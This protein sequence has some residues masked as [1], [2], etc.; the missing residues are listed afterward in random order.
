MIYRNIEFTPYRNFTKKEKT[1]E[2]CPEV[3][4]KLRHIASFPITDMTHAEF[5]EKAKEQKEIADAYSVTLQ[6][7]GKMYVVPCGKCFM[8]ID[9]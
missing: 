5:Y 8:E 9:K 6:G 1:P 4:R 2:R 3:M 7:K